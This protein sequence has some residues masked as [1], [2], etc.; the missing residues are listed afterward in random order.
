MQLGEKDT[1]TGVAPCQAQAEALRGGGGQVDVIVHPGAPHAWDGPN[2][3]HL[4][5]V[6]N[7]SD[8][9][10]SEG[11]DGA[12]Y[13]TTTKARVLDSSGAVLTDGARVGFGACSRL[14][15]EGGP[16]EAATR[17]GTAAAVAFL[18]RILKL[19]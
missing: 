8:C 7:L 19:P 6:S 4:A 17:N 5:Q 16:D 1:W 13:E 3:F 11:E 10:L 14:G 2:A 12:F 15:V 9:I 18:S